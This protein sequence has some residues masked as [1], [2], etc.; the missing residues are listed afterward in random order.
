[1]PAKDSDYHNYIFSE[2]MSQ[3]RS[4]TWRRMKEDTYRY[5]RANPQKIDQDHR[6]H[7][8]ALKRSFTRWL[9]SNFVNREVQTL[10]VISYQINFIGVKRRWRYFQR[11]TSRILRSNVA[12]DFIRFRSGF[13]QLHEITET[14]QI[15]GKRSSSENSFLFE[16]KA[17]VARS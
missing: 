12:Y 4:R 1:M 16:W 17:I 15:F 14:I 8:K 7:P 9:S 5:N 13:I 11:H 6:L 10:L 3:R 2:R